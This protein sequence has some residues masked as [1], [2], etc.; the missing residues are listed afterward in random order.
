M[1]KLAI[2]FCSLF[3][4]PEIINAQVTYSSDIADIIYKNCSNCHREGE[5]GPFPL[6][7]YEEVSERANMIKFVTQS[8]YMP[9]WKADPDFSS[10]IDE[11]YL[12]QSEIDMISEWADNG[13]PRGDAN[14]EPAFPNFP[15]GS[16]LGEPD[17]VLEMTESHLH[18]GNNR[19]SY[20]YFV[21]PNPL[22]EDKVVKAVEFRAGNTKIVHHALIFED[23]NGVAAATDA[24]TPEY[25]F[26]SF[27][28]FN[29]NDNDLQF[30]EEKQFPPYAPGQ[31][32]L[33]YPDGLGQIL[34]AG[35]DI[36]VQIHYAP[37]SSD[38]IDQS[39]IN[40]FFADDTESVD[41]IVDNDILLPFN[42]PGGFFNFFIP[43]NQEREF[44]GR[45]NITD[46]LS[47]LGIFPHSHLLGKEWEAWIEHTD[48]SRTN[49]ISI[50]EWDFNWQS[51]FYFDKFI[52]AEKGSRIFARALYDNTSSNPN[53]PNNP[54]QIVGWGDRTTDEMYYMPFMFVPY[55]AGDEDI[56]FND[57]TSS[58]EDIKNL[59]NQSVLFPL[60]PNPIAG[61]TTVKFHLAQGEPVDIAI[62]NIQGQLVRQL[63][64]GEF[65]TN[66]L[67][68]IQFNAHTLQ[69]GTYFLTI[70]GK[71]LQLVEKFVKV[72]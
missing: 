69:N 16:L 11:T 4:L 35:S 46:D 28:G 23:R 36:A 42:L 15:E 20:Y 39:S 38:E 3:V 41:R 61:S 1:K 29:G 24:S 21:L 25:G 48:G 60:I 32:A 51:T 18:R 58:V 2:L 71:N 50:P 57:G 72:N 34:K 63:R 33:R 70:Q 66:G 19:D 8:R 52:K 43:A 5:I 54:P 14:E 30:L 45:W 12:E 10:F 65:F 59:G 47:L 22:A 62:T 53:N 17:L 13:A 49:L 26:E 37:T 44:L 27:G 56:V 9:P 67:N 64:K 55:Q 7:N 6:T 68:Q 40:F 31:K